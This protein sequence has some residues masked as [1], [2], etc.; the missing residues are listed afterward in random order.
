MRSN[1]RASR[2]RRSRGRRIGPCAYAKRHHVQ[3]AANNLK[4]HWHLA[5]RYNKPDASLNPFIRAR[6]IILCLNRE[7]AIGQTVIQGAELLGK[8][9]AIYSVSQYHMQSTEVV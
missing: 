6:T 1:G 8:T 3:Q 9:A 4:Q 2:G 7:Q 5:T